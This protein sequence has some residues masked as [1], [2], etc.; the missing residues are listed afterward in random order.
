MIR[1]RSCRCR[2]FR[3]CRPLSLFPLVS[4]AGT[5]AEGVGDLYVWQKRSTMVE[6]IAWLICLGIAIKL[7]EIAG[8]PSNRDEHGRMR[9]SLAAGVVIG[10]FAL[11]FA[12]IAIG[13]QGG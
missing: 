6:I 13:G 2:S 8:S 10:W 1:S 7:F 11:L 4:L 5:V 9:T 3:Q 12:A